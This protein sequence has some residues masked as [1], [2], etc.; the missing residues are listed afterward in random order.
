MNS[1]MSDFTSTHTTSPEQV[2]HE[3]ER[4]GERESVRH[5]V[6]VLLPVKNLKSPS[7]AAGLMSSPDADVN[8]CVFLFFLQRR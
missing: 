7:Q 1:L 3:R 8:C 2:P 5:H 6:Y 4:E